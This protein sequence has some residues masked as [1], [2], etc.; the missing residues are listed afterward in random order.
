MI[1]LSNEFC[2][3]DEIPCSNIRSI[4]CVLPDI[5]LGNQTRDIL[6][7]DRVQQGVVIDMTSCQ[8]ASHLIQGILV[9]IPL[10]IPGNKIDE[11]GTRRRHDLRRV[12]SI[13]DRPCNDGT[14][15]ERMNRLLTDSSTNL[16][17]Y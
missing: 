4:L 10:D 11:T 15:L 17:I 14:G 7:G 2:S 9:H 6:L 5:H 3:Y 16:T 8:T 13:F 1:Q 12:V